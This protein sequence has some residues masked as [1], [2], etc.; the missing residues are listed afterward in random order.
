MTV[1]KNHTNNVNFVARGIILGLITGCLIGLGV[2][3]I[4]GNW[5]IWVSFGASLGFAAGLIAAIVLA[6]RR[7]S[8]E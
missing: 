1:Q 2:G 3:A 7:T 6:E 4:V 8:N 5:R